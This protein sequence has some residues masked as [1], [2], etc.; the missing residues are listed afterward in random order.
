M[1][2]LTR[3]LP[4]AADEIAPDGLE[5]RLLLAGGGGSFAHFRLGAGRTGRAVRHRTVEEIWYFTE[6]EGAFWREGVAGGAPVPVRPG[7]SVR[8]PVGTGFQLRAGP[9]GPV[10]AVAVTMPPWPGEGEAEVIEGCWA[11]D[12]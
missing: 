12:L 1:D 5:V 4:G 9:G 11:P 10:S 7:T 2:D 6:G 3:Q 8:I